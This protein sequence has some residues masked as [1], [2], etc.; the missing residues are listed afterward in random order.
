M[1]H[2]QK[3]RYIAGQYANTNIMRPEILDGIRD[4]A[5]AFVQKCIESKGASMD[6]YVYLHCFAL[7]CAS[8]F[9]FHPYGTHSIERKEDFEMMEEQSYHNSLKGQQPS[10]PSDAWGM[11]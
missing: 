9:L 1:Q 6:A 5:D 3:K 11:S 2:S 4:R 7:D 10:F 8:H